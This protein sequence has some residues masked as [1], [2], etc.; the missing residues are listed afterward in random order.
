MNNLLHAYKRIIAA[1]VTAA[2]VLTVAV[3][4]SY[5]RPGERTVTVMLTVTTTNTVTASTIGAFV[6]SRVYEVT[7]RQIPCYAGSWKLAYYFVHP[8]SVTLGGETIIRPVNETSLFYQYTNRLGVVQET[9]Y[10]NSSSNISTIVFSVSNGT[11]NYQ[12]V[13]PD[14]FPTNRSSGTLSVSGSDINLHLFANCPS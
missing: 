7:F 3:A 12:I 5:Y 9:G 14:G 6:S 4:V 13:P 8:W 1:V 11:Y 2:M 10:S